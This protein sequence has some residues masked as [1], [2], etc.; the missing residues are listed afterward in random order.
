M[1]LV[2]SYLWDFG[3]GSSSTEPSPT[4]IYERPGIYSVTLVITTTDTDTNDVTTETVSKSDYIAVSYSP[5]NARRTN[6]SFTLGLIGGEQGIGFSENTGEFPMPEARTGVIKVLDD[7]E[8][9]HVVVLDFKNGT[10]YDITTRNGP[11][12]SGLVEVFKDKVGININGYQTDDTNGYD[13]PCEVAFKEDKG[14]LEKYFIEH[15]ETNVYVRP[16]DEDNRDEIGFDDKGFLTG[17]QFEIEAYVDGEPDTYVAKAE[18]IGLKGN[19]VYDRKVEG[20]RVQTRFRSTKGAFSIV[21][22]QIDYIAKDKPSKVEDRIMTEG[23]YQEVLVPD[24]F[25]FSRGTNPFSN[26]VR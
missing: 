6:K 15:L 24:V 23:D 8:Q 20:H 16:D 7:N 2:Y 21:G 5:I 25:W 3:D 17:I 19:V 12:G 11:K 10:F 26:R 4:H 22:R 1:A 13:I 9:P 14:E 18:D